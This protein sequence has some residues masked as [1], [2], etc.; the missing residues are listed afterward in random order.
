MNTDLLEVNQLQLFNYSSIKLS[1][2]EVKVDFSV[3]SLHNLMK[4]FV[5]LT[6]YYV[7]IENLIIQNDIFVCTEQF[8]LKSLLNKFKKIELKVDNLVVRHLSNSHN[9][10]IMSVS[11]DSL[12]VRQNNFFVYFHKKDTVNIL[13]TETKVEIREL[14]ILNKLNKPIVTLESLPFR[15]KDKMVYNRV[16]HQLSV[17]KVLVSD[18]F[19]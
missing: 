16:T 7:N 10:T 2:C 17:V 3:R 9:Y 8:I 11:A 15:I 18:V 5:I 12:S 14:K 4:Y 13:K 1:V 19:Q 6:K